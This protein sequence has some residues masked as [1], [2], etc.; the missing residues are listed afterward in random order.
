M[1]SNRWDVPNLGSIPPGAN[2]DGFHG[3]S[4]FVLTKATALARFERSLLEWDS[5]HGDVNWRA[6]CSDLLQELQ[7][8]VPA[9]EPSVSLATWM[10]TAV[11]RYSLASTKNFWNFFTRL[12]RATKVHLN[13]AAT[14]DVSAVDP[15]FNVDTWTAAEWCTPDNSAQV[16]DPLWTVERGYHLLSSRDL[17]AV[18]SSVI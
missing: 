9:T 10:S 8:A 2:R 1:I 4:R 18:W 11:R 6:F 7:P 16:S 5:R 17:K 12:G 15:T 13:T 3:G 14:F